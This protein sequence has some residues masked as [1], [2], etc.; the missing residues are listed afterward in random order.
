M[1]TELWEQDHLSKCKRE[2]METAM[3]L[4]RN[5]EMLRV[6]NPTYIRTYITHIGTYVCTYIHVCTYVHTYATGT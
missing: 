4:E 3:E 6:N 5:R 1:F 2:E